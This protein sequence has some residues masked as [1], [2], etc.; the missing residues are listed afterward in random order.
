MERP[1]RRRD[2]SS[3]SIRLADQLG[4]TTL[5]ERRPSQHRQRRSSQRA[6][7]YSRSAP[8]GLTDPYHIRHVRRS[9][10]DRDSDQYAYRR[11]ES[12]ESV[13]DETPGRHRR[14]RVKEV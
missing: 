14:V 2:P 7:E 3:D 11:S 1:R 4:R 5:E 13:V 9:D 10:E 6:I 8:R 12:E